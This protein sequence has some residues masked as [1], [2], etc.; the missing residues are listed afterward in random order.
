MYILDIEA[1]G[2]GDDSYPVEIAWCHVDGSQSF[3]TLIN[4][5]SVE[6]W[7]GWSDEATRRGLARQECC[8]RG[9][10]A[11]YVA[12]RV[13]RLLTGYPVFS[14]SPAQDQKWLDALFSA[15]G[16][17]KPVQLMPLARAVPASKRCALNARLTSRRDALNA[18]ANC[19]LLCREIR[20][21]NTSTKPEKHHQSVLG[22]SLK[23]LKDFSFAT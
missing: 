15:T 16:K 5:D 18:A 4:P 20:Q 17:P 8:E 10:P 21:V 2:I 13:S 14:E 23:W 11:A 7:V 19:L 1:S 9:E 22:S 12:Q 6:S 3:S